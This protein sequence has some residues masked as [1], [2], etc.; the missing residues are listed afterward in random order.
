MLWPD[1]VHG[2]ELDLSYRA[3]EDRYPEIS[4]LEQ[5]HWKQRLFEGDVYFVKNKSH[6]NNNADD[7]KRDDGG[8]TPR[9]LSVAP[10]FSKL[11]SVFVHK[12]Q[13]VLHKARSRQ[14]RPEAY[15]TSPP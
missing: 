2:V 13:F 4:D 6:Q 12:D 15:K 14:I 3:H 10:R 8:A 9:I 5:R 1:H 11:V 7:Q